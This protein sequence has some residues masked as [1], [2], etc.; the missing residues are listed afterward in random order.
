MFL[1]KK[2]QVAII[3]KHA[4]LYETYGEFLIDKQ[5][6]LSQQDKKKHKILNGKKLL[7]FKIEVI[8]NF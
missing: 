2:R 3:C 8:W 5:W 1:N 7:S 6:I 4:W